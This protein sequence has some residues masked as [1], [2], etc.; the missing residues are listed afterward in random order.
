MYKQGPVECPQLSDG[1]ACIGR[2]CH[3]FEGVPED[4]VCLQ[5]NIQDWTLESG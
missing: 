1:C 2:A 5:K 3:A 4:S